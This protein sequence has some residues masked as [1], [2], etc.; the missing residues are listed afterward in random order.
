MEG[1]RRFVVRWEILLGLWI[2]ASKVRRSC[3]MG[4]RILDERIKSVMAL[5]RVSGAGV[6]GY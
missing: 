1:K 3:G 2:C 5:M 4:G 6:A